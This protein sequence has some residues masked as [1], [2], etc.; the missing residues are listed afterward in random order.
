MVKTFRAIIIIFILCVLCAGVTSCGL[1]KPR[2]MKAPLSDLPK[3][4]PLYGDMDKNIKA[5][6]LDKWWLSFDSSELDKLIEESMKGNFGIQKAWYRLR[7]VQSLAKE[8]RSGLFPNVNISAG[9]SHSRQRSDRNMFNKP[10]TT[11][12]KQ[13]SLGVAGSYELDLWNKIGSQN[14]AAQLDVKA[15]RKELDAAA[16]TLSAAITIKWISIISQRIQRQLLLDQLKTNKQYLDLVNLKFRKSM[17]SALDVYQQKQT[18]ARIEAA[19]PLVDAQEKELMQEL[20]LLL[21]KTPEHKLKITADK[22]PRIGPI[23]DTG[24]PADLLAS[25]PD[26]QAAGMRLRAAQFRLAAARANRLPSFRLTANA[27][28]GSAKWSTLFDNWI[29]TLAG[30][31]AEPI[32]DAGRLKAEEN[33]NRAIQDENLIAYRE[34]VVTAIKEVENALMRESLQHQHITGLKTQ[35]QAAQNALQQARKRYMNGM[36][37][38]LPVLIQLLKVQALQQEIIQAQTTLLIY[39]VNLYRSLGGSWMGKLKQPNNHTYR[40]KL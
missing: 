33:R 26:I 32:F 27:N 9:L 22:L 11:N 25:R 34:T 7:Q 40:P 29:M 20:D 38:Y 8:T 16:M 6:R 37:D 18:V 5:P 4:Y 21:G 30:N 12:F 1:F 28:Y 10:V 35:L 2:T 31:L 39:R 23:P 24:L 17:V 13:Y 14:K 19:L 36:I 15:T 3:A